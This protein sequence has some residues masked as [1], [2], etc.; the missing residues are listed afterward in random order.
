MT[1]DLTRLNAFINSTLAKNRGNLSESE[2]WNLTETLL[3]TLEEQANGTANFTEIV[4]VSGMKFNVTEL[5]ALISDQPGA[6]SSGSTTIGVTV[7]RL[8]TTDGVAVTVD[9]YTRAAPEDPGKSQVES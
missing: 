9:R 2:R 4:T 8:V 3:T 6:P 7:D 1:S 5:D